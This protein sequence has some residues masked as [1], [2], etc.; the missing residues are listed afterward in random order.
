MAT[1][2][3]PPL[4]ARPSAAATDPFS[5]VQ[6]SRSFEIVCEKV[7]ER[8]VQGELRPGDKLPAER[9]LAVQLGVSRN[10]VREALRS[11][12]IAGVIALK[13]GAKGGAFIKE[14]AASSITQALSDLIT[15]RAVTLKDL[16]EARIMILEMVID[17]AF[18]ASAP[19]NLEALE[20]IV[21]KTTIAAR[22]NAYTDRVRL[23]HDFY[24]ELA[25]LTGNTAILFM[26]D[27]Q[28]ELVQTFLRYRVGELDADTLIASRRAFLEHLR[29]GDTKAAK[30]NLRE[31]LNRIHTSLW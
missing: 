25:N 17:R 3:L 15:L 21:E 9:E 14:G 20:K 27:G 11:L 16:F 26:V 29:A 30:A 31:H 6:S 8:L 23:A 4:K 18:G 5:P 24:H 2:S 12:E 28:T 7:R 22:E 1:P 13:K 10:V 19:P